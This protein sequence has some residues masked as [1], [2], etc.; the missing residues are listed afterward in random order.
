MSANIDL[1]TSHKGSAHITTQN[2]IDLISGLTGNIS[3]V[4]VFSGLYNGLAHEIIDTLEVRVKTGAALADGYFFLLTEA[5][6]WILDPGTVGYSRIDILY[7]V[8]YED[9]DTNVQSA[10]F[11][12]QVGADYPNGTTGTEPDAPSDPD[13]I[14]AHKLVRMDMT[15][16]AIVSV[17]DY[18]T[19]YL[20]ND[21]LAET[22]TNTV[23]ELE[24]NIGGTVAQVTANSNA[25]NGLR[26][27]VDSNG[28]YGYYKAGADSVTPFRDPK[29]NA[30]AADVLSGKSFANATNDSVNGSMSNQGAWTGTGTPSG[31]NQVNVSIPAG[32]H[33][34]NGYVT[35]KGQTAYAAGQTA[36]YSAGRTQGQSD[37]KACT[38]QIAVQKD[39]AGTLVAVGCDG[40]TLFSEWITESTAARSVQVYASYNS[41]VTL[42]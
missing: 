37:K 34:G 4:K 10:D 40:R 35:C 33:N 9:P 39:F 21:S 25:L 8:I 5:F 41:G 2:V 27:G 29:G 3:G 22:I 31:N 1:V 32:Y 6:D 7:L 12:Y 24:E 30:T 14:G 13:I 18:A 15:D 16:G 17:T 26:F 20:S 36:G 11:V 38:L 19:P 28:K 23:T 42:S